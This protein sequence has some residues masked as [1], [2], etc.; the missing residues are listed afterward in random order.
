VDIV[1]INLGT[2]FP[3]PPEITDALIKSGKEILRKAE[4]AARLAGIAVESHLI[5]IDTLAHRIPEMIAADAEAWPADLIVICT[6]GR[7]GLSH[8]FLGSIAEGVVRVATKPVLL[9]RG[10]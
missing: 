5:E 2:E 10:K 9:I 1:N 7:R 8:L 6:H 4:A 3:N